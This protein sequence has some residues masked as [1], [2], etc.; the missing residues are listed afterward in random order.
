MI[1][2]VCSFIVASAILAI[3]PGPDNIFVL[4]QSISQGKK[5][6]MATVFGL[7]LGCLVHTSL[8][9]FGVG[10]II[11]SSNNL[12]F[13][14]QSL[15]AFYMLFLAFK[16]FKSDVNMTIS[17]NNRRQTTS[18][19]AFKTGLLMNVLNPKVTLFFLAF[20]PSFLF[21]ERL[22]TILQFYVLGVVF[23]IVTALIFSAI[24]LF[25]SSLSTFIGRSPSMRRNLKWLQILVFVS[26]ALYILFA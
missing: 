9:A 21:S 2:T 19:Q 13:I 20:F 23:M 12:I 3:S 14:I 6:G 26:I 18:F 10:T 7:V 8:I 15:G 17:S 1:E 16:V 25:S 4:T 5:T 24:V 11:S 22:S